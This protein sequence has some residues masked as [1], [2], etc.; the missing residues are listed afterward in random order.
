MTK[1]T[2]K[3]L[4][5]IITV[6]LTVVAL[7]TTTFAWFT[8]TNSAA[9]QTFEAD[10]IADSGIEIA[11]GTADEVADNMGLN[12]V[13][14]LTT[15]AIE[16]F[17]ATKYVDAF[18]FNHVTTIDGE[19]FTT[20]G[21]G[22]A[23]GPVYN[24]FLELPLHFRSN[25]ANGIDWTSVSLNSTQFTW[26]ADQAFNA[27]GYD[28]GTSSYIAVP[29]SAGTL[30]PLNAADAFRISIQETIGVG[31]KLTAYERPA[32]TATPYNHVLGIGGTGY[33]GIINDPDGTPGTGDEAYTGTFGAHSYYFSDSQ[34][35][36]FGIEDFTTVATVTSI[37]Q[38]RVLDMLDTTDVLNLAYDNA[39]S[40]YYGSIT[41][42]IWLEGWDLNAYNAIL[43]QTIRS[44]FQFTGVDAV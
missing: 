29:V 3:L 25:S 42:R 32:T 24:G 38:T 28:S 7:G 8:L 15:Q 20:L 2:K 27:I 12:W 40:Q 39:G 23:G 19:N 22:A 4:L 33:E 13:T 1:I 6:V 30:I 31:S 14:T 18:R 35:S 36:P 11:I 5:S 26:S 16:D 44:S 10:I 37:T 17:I 43:S 41:I 34:T 9:V 21:L